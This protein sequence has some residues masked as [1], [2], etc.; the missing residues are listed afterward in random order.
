MAAQDTTS[1]GADAGQEPVTGRVAETVSASWSVSLDDLRTNLT[2]EKNKPEDIENFVW[3][4]LYCTDSAHPMRREEF[5]RKIAVVDHTTI[6][7]LIRGTYRHPETGERMPI[8]EKLGRALTM[9]RQLET[10]RARNLRPAISRTPT[11]ARIWTACDLAR[12]SQS[13]VFL[14]G[15]SHIGKTVGLTSYRDDHDHGM[16]CYARLRAAS[17]LGGMIKEIALA[18]GGIGMKGN[19]ATLIESI[20]RR[21]K[22]N[23]LLIL[24]EVHELMYTYRKESFF[25]CLE[26]IR[27]I[28][29]ACGCGLLLCGTS[30]LMKR[31]RENRGELEQLLRRGV[32]KVILPSQPTKEDLTVILGDYNLHFP[33]KGY[34]CAVR[35][36]TKD[37]SDTPY[38]ILRQ[39]GSED[40]LKAITERLRYGLKFARKDNARLKWEHVVR[41]HLTI[42]QN[43][44]PGDDW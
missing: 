42:K 35:F 17:G 12:E 27:E 10:D 4:Y 44:I 6:L 23:M 29:D 39:V 38:E 2:H 15:P 1:T 13:P 34:T 40:G 37:I 41:A 28:Y 7:K 3:C 33:E 9:F 22:P 8:P 5:A 16:T 43:E 32:H 19:T 14:I 24:D 11:L 31:V 26:V 20:K 25:A 36:G 30:L 18:I 21:L